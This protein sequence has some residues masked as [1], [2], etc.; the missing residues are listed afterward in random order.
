MINRRQVQ[1]AFFQRF[2]LQRMVC[3]IEKRQKGKEESE[4]EWQKIECDPKW[5]ALRRRCFPLSL[6]SK[7]L[8]KQKK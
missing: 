5:N 1:S 2:F 4:Q 7:T 6:L 3:S 8:K